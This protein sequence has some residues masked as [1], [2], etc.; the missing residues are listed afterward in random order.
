MTPEYPVGIGGA[1][2][3]HHQKRLVQRHIAAGRAFKCLADA[4]AGGADHARVDGQLPAIGDGDA[5]VLRLVGVED[6]RDIVLGMAGGEQHAR[7]RENAGAA[8]CAQP[9]EAVLDHRV[10][11]FEIAVFHRPV[12]KAGLEP[13]GKLCEFT[14]RTAVAAAVAANHQPQLLACF[15]R[16]AGHYAPPSNAS[17]GRS[18]KTVPKTNSCFISKA[19]SRPDGQCPLPGAGLLPG[20]HWRRWRGRNRSRTPCRTQREPR[21]ACQ[22]ART[23]PDWIPDMGRSAPESLSV[24]PGTPSLAGHASGAG[25]RHQA[26]NPAK[27]VGGAAAL[28]ETPA[29]SGG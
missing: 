9:V 4:I 19:P 13:L 20:H 17:E 21:N 25:R 22:T 1:A 10:G 3:D 7:H 12:G 23:A 29:C 18:V 27:P 28:P 16:H 8:L 11:E 15:V 2:P 14:D 26:P 24:P 5:R 6:G